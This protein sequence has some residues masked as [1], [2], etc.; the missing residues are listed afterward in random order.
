MHI[1]PNLYEKYPFFIIIRKFLPAR[2][3]GKAGLA[4]GDDRFG[5]VAI[6]DQ[7]AAGIAGQPGI[8]WVL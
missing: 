4:A 6:L 3:D 8:G 5:G 1:P 2:L 7:Q